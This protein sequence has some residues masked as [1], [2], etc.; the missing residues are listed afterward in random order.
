MSLEAAELKMDASH[1]MILI[2]IIFAATS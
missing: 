1:Q 2:F